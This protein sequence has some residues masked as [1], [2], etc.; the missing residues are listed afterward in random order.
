MDGQI[1]TGGSFLTTLTD[2]Y[3]TITESVTDSG[4]KNGTDSI[5]ITVGSP[6]PAAA[7]SISVET[8]NGSYVNREQVLITVTVTDGT[9]PVEGAAVHVDLT[10]ANEKKFAGEGTTDE[11]G[12]AK[13]I[14]KVNSKRD[15]VG[16]YTLDATAS[17]AGYTSG[18]GSTTFAVTK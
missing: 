1:G 6:T 5:S 4:G 8:D 14:Y 17:K 11:S 18:S 12:V 3:H 7:L 15:G 13:F 2:G 9:N 16:T 10:T